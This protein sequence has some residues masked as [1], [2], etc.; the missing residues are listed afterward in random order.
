MAKIKYEVGDFIEIHDD[1][2]LCG[3]LAANQGTIV[4]IGNEG[5]LRFRVEEPWGNT[6]AG[7]LYWIKDSWI[8]NFVGTPKPIEEEANVPGFSS[9]AG[10]SKIKIHR[11]YDENPINSMYK[12][13]KK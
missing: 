9:V 6:K 2:D 4:E 13:L 3:D 1:Y 12:N 5:Y 11:G 8:Y 10:L 7:D